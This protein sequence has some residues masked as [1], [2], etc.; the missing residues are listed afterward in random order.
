MNLLKTCLKFSLLLIGLSL[1]AQYCGMHQQSI[2]VLS[3]RLLSNKAASKAGLIEQRMETQYVPI[4]FH[5]VAKDDGSQRVPEGEVLDQLCSLNQDF[6]G[7]DIQF[8]IKEFNYIDNTTLFEEH[9]MASAQMDNEQ[10]PFGL[11]IFIFKSANNDTTLDDGVT[12]GYYSPNKDWLVMRKDQIN[13]RS[14]VLTHEMGHFFSLLHPYH[15]WDREPWDAAIHGNPSPRTSPNGVRTELMNGSNCQNAG[16]FLCDT[17]PDYFFA[18]G[19]ENCIYDGGALDPN[20]DLVD[21]D[22]LNYMSNFLNECDREAY[23]FSPRQ[24]EMMQTDLQSAQR[25]YLRVDFTPFAE[26]IEEETT[27]L[28]P[29][30]NATVE[31]YNLVGLNWEVVEGADQYLVEIDRV[32]TFTVQPTRIITDNTFLEVSLEPEKR[33][34]W[35]VR[36]FNRY[37]TCTTTTTPSVFFTGNSAGETSL[38]LAWNVFPNPARTGTNLQLEINTERSFEA[39]F[40]LFNSVGQLIDKRT[41]AI[42]ALERMK[43]LD[44]TNLSAGVYIARITVGEERFQ[45]KFVIVN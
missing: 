26:N 25:R 9:G 3:Q 39:R 43:E 42:S 40:E 38:Q 18:F 41:L 20:G 19:W 14:I 33:Y 11:D 10:D 29:E 34:Y 8:Y 2:E 28:N 23:H 16:D 4:T 36:P 1:Q 32:P 15:G 12:F 31:S 27:L 37:A 45:Q 5:L 30:K 44:S 35:R 17:P 21:P 6:E 24:E 7:L 22:E 13:S